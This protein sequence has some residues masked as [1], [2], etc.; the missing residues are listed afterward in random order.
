MQHFGMC[1]STTASYRQCLLDKE[2]ASGGVGDEAVPVM[3]RRVTWA[4]RASSL[5]GMPVVSARLWVGELITIGLLTT[6]DFRTPFCAVKGSVGL[7][8]HWIPNCRSQ[9]QLPLVSKQH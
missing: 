6:D 2:L 5:S 7:L 8:I 1:K 9:G 4:T 3:R